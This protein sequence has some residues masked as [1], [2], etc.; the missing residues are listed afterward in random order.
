M[1]YTC[2]GVAAYLG[3]VSSLRFQR[4]RAIHK[5]YTYKTRESM[6]KMTDHDAFSIQKTILQTEFPFIVLKSLQ[7]AL[8]RVRHPK[9]NPP[10]FNPDKDTDIRH[11]DNLI[12]P[13]QNLPILQPHHLIQTLRRHRHPN[14]RI[15]GFRPQF[16]ARPNSHSPHQ[17]PSPR[18]PRQRED[19]R[20]RHA[21][22]TQSLC[23]RANPLRAAIRVAVH[24]G[25]G[26]LRCRDI[27]E[28]SG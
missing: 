18:L 27:L 22:H 10:F 28:E 20:R 19:S 1:L 17:F 5:K 3:L 12:P 4:Q 11:P 21:L 24:D 25:N 13:P 14:R 15:H 7:F 26:T 2:L 23:H 6:S 16:R 8:F 9:S